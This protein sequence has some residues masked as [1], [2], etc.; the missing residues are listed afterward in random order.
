MAYYIGIMS[1]TS[2]D[3]LDIALIEQSP[4]KLSQ[5]VGTHYIPMPND[6][7]KELLSLCSAGNDEL[8]RAAMAENYWATLAATGIETLLAKHQ[9]TGKNITAIGSHGQTVRHEPKR[10]FTIQISNGALL[11]ELTGITVITDFRR[12]DVAAGGQGAPLVPAYH[13]ALFKDNTKRRAILN[14]G[15]FSNLSLL[16]PGDITHG[17]DC[18]PGNV[19]LDTWI[20][21]K[22]NK[23][24]DQS[25]DWAAS[26]PPDQQLLSIF[27]SDPFF[28]QTGP[29]STGRELFNFNWL[30]EKLSLFNKTI[31]DN[32]VQSTLLELTIRTIVDSL[33]KA[34]P[35]TDELIVCGGGAFNLELL[36]RLQQH[37]PNTRVQTTQ[38]YGIDPKWVEAMAF[39]WLAYCCLEKIPANCPAVTG[40]KGVRVLGAIYPA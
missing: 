11:A 31:P 21:Y 28:N 19:L 5:L 34:Q 27:L 36:K 29:K 39:A 14:I 1:G 18:G 8:S 6:L 17:F 33:K 10:N 13:E 7:R 3:G 15:G 26:I 12:R 9:L 2:L 4:T 38:D 30:T 23:P 22:L 25:G 16:S 40:A 35:H 32:T 37:L 20:S 24:Y